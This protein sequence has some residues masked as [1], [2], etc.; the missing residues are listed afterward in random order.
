MRTWA[1]STLNVNIPTRLSGRESARRETIAARSRAAGPDTA[2]AGRGPRTAVGSSPRRRG[3]SGRGARPAPRR[4]R[5]PRGRCAGRGP[6]C[7]VPGYLTIINNSTPLTLKYREARALTCDRCEV[8]HT[9][10]RR[11]NRGSEPD[12]T[13]KTKNRRTVKPLRYEATRLGGA[14]REGDRATAT[15][16]HALQDTRTRPAL[17]TGDPRSCT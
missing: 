7:G 2:D 9:D 14:K 12:Q 6:A 16:R 17:A 11:D 10:T 1:P 5:G 4:G 13:F 15:C 3:R 8:T